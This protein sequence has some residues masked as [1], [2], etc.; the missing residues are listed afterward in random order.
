[1]ISVGHLIASLHDEVSIS[2]LY[3]DEKLD[4]CVC[5]CLLG[6]TVVAG[7]FCTPAS[8]LFNAFPADTDLTLLT[9]CAVSGD[10]SWS[11]DR[12][13]LIILLNEP[14]FLRVRDWRLDLRFREP[15]LSLS[16]TLLLRRGEAV[17]GERWSCEGLND[18]V[19]G[20]SLFAV[21]G[22]LDGGLAT[23]GLFGKD[24]GLFSIVRNSRTSFSNRS[25]IS[26]WCVFALISKSF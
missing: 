9:G 14:D 3:G 17:G 25:L 7:L 15:N 10:C 20:D 1:M 16:K 12:L 6:G 8:A 11:R 5:D 26:A 23:G 22:G 21:M 18:F 19:E 2:S 4:W 24:G 13:R